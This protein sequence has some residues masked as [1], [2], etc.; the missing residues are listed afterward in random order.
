MCTPHYMS[1][2]QCLGEELDQRSDIYSLGV[3]LYEMLAAVVPFNSP[4][5]T[6]I[7]VQ[8]VSGTPAPL[9]VLNV[10]IPPAVETV[11]MRALAKRREDRPQTAGALAQ[12]LAGAVAATSGAFAPVAQIGY[13]DPDLQR[14]TGG[15][16]PT[17]Q[18]PTP[19]QVT[20]THTAVS[21]TGPPTPA[22]HPPKSKRALVLGLA[23]V[24]LLAS[25]VV[26]W[27]VP[28]DVSQPAPA[29]E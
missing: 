2:E 7:V 3:V 21:V 18:M 8:H 28:R 6:A 17:M 22:G 25:A 5:S 26:G 4:T 9:R 1:P 14:A 20:P 29:V 16:L 12:E 13:F 24:F 10:S 23:G 15:L 19:Q 27:L 11:V